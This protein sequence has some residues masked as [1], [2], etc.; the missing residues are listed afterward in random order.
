MNNKA[1]RSGGLG[2][3]GDKKHGREEENK[4]RKGRERR[5]QISIPRV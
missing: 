1:K 5:V 4:G 2:V 3:W